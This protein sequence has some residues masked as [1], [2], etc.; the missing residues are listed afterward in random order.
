[1]KLMSELKTPLEDGRQ[2]ILSAAA[3]L[4]HKPGVYRM[5]DAQGDVLYVGKA[6]AL[7]KRVMS[8]TR[9][10]AL[11]IRLKR[12]VAQTARM[13]FVT[14]HTEAEALLLEANLIKSLEPKFNILLKDDKSYPYIL[15]RTDHDYPL[16]VK[17]RGAKQKRAGKYYG[18]FAGAG[19]VMRTLKALQRVFL[20]RN[21]SD[22]NFVGR[23]RPCLQ[24]HIKRCTAPCVGYVSKDEYA[25]Q[26]TDAQD[27]LEGRSDA[28]QERF[29]EQMEAASQIQDYERAALM[30]D[31]L[32]SLMA[33][34]ARQDIHLDGVDD[35]D[36]IG[37]YQLDG[38]TCIQVFF[39]RGGQNLGNRAYFP[40]HVA[41][42][43][44]EQIIASFLAQFYLNKPVPRVVMVSHA[45]EAQD[46]LVD[47]LS[48]MQSALGKVALIVP[49]RGK[50]R[51]AIDFAIMNAREAL[52]RHLTE[53]RSQAALLEAMRQQFDLPAL[54]RRIEVYDNS[55]L[56]GTG[57]IGGMIVAGPQGFEKRAYRKFNMRDAAAGDD[58]GMMAEVMRRRF[59]GTENGA[60][61]PGT[62]E[63]P[64]VLLIDGGKGQLSSVMEV[65]EGYGIADD[66]TVIAIAKGEDRNA[67]RERFFMPDRAEFTLQHDAP[68]M[69][70]LQRL[71]D[72]SHRFVIG[73]QRTRR[74][75]AVDKTS[76]DSIAGI[77]AKKRAAL[78]RHFG[79]AKAVEGASMQDLLN[80]D[81]ISK[82]L[83]EFIY[84]HFRS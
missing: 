59:R 75:K 29:R 16:A 1:M 28:L 61:A 6:K 76:L 53:A 72:E 63:W 32:K 56:G 15:M 41:E 74:L 8:Y 26:V 58:Y 20:L 82:R 81:G 42:E 2:V 39:F 5:I 78:I 3:D 47:A 68:L 83:A 35:A 38:R 33:I 73:A 67:G 40:R 11:P 23:E 52:E 25:Q 37:L 12:M 70:Y 17:Y 60:L 79:S 10:A 54:P 36:V 71:R 57:Q 14:T 80:V 77:G 84:S 22:N 9:V 62:A 18:P 45:P 21:C 27:F 4:T 64:D 65:L 43:G 69:H 44:T 51:A 30:R 19:H 49:K 31:R 34:A 55:H 48:G 24:Y 13:E 7:R 46:V 66:L 50:K